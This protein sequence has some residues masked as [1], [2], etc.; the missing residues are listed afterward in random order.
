M[1][2][3]DKRRK[4][5]TM[6]EEMENWKKQVKQTE[7]FIRRGVTHDGKIIRILNRDGSISI[8]NWCVPAENQIRELYR[9]LVESDTNDRLE[10]VLDRLYV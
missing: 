10:D 2:C 5:E 8:I 6:E 9:L 3:S 7:D 1:G 4:V